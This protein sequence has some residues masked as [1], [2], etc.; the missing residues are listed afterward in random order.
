MPIGVYQQMLAD[1][2]PPSGGND[3]NTILL[4][5]MD[6]TNGSTSFPDSSASAN[7]V[8]PSGS[9]SVSTSSPKFGTGAMNLPSGS[10]ATVSNSAFN[11]GS[12]DFTVDYW[13]KVGG[14]IT[15][16]PNFYSLSKG[17]SVNGVNDGWVAY[18]PDNT[19]SF[20][21]N[22]AS[23]SSWDMFSPLGT[24][25]ALVANTWNHVAFVRHGN[26][27][28]CYLNGTSFGTGTSS[29]SIKSNAFAVSIGD[30]AVGAGQTI[31][32]DEVRISNVAR[33]TANF[34]PPAAP[35]S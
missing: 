4:L 26:A 33:W 28:A 25:A 3:A 10:N 21:V 27:F 23:T 9:T 1:S 13:I 2:I 12:G 29:A 14:T 15:G 7:S 35:Y 11:F 22:S 34:T 20:Y 19:I 30:G 6:G 24:S 8:T 16:S 32:F 31:Q 17:G 5:H 18:M